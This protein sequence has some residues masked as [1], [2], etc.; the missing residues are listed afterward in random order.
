MGEFTSDLSRKEAGTPSDLESAL[1]EARLRQFESS[2]LLDAAQSIPMAENFAQSARAIFDSCCKVTGATAGYVALLNDAGDENEVLFLEAGGLPCTVDPNLPMPIRGLR[3]VSYETSKAVYDNDFSNSKWMKFMPEGHVSLKNV[4]FSP[5]NVAGKT[6]GLIGLANKAEDFTD[7]DAANATTFG[8]MASVALRFARYQD[9]LKRWAHVFEDA[10]WGVAVGDPEYNSLEMI[11]PAFAEMHGYALEELASKPISTVFAEAARETL[12][13]QLGLARDK[14][15]HTFETENVRKDGSVFPTQ[16][17]VTMVE[18]KEPAEEGHG[19]A[20]EAEGTPS[21]YYVFNVQDITERKAAADALMRS[22]IELRQ[23]ASIAA[24]QLQEPLRLISSYTQLLSRRYA[25]KL[26]DEASEFIEYAVSGSERLQRL[27]D[28]LLVYTQVGIDPEA[29]EAVDCAPLV[30]EVV[31]DMSLVIDSSGA[32]V[33]VGELPSVRANRKELFQLFRHMLQNAIDN[34]GPGQCQI[35]ISAE[36]E[37]GAW[38]LHVKDNG[39]GIAPRH[40]ERIFGLFTRL[41]GPAEGAGTGIGLALCK[42]IV[43]RYGGRIWVE[44]EEG[45]G[46]SFHFTF[47]I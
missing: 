5:I 31:N 18:E 28:G 33:V 3:G 10:K 23:Y 2:E 25:G 13:Q 11:N 46:A 41:Q 40:H 12:V 34:A 9:Q 20:E 4:M 16:V 17:D 1:Q 26:D 7:R 37:E 14:G 45:E 19:E 27:L 43:E 30:N 35:D 22:N 36:R 8:E 32:E 21:K 38:H 29:V 44:S 15:H 47:P 42:K 24:H 6:V 39:I